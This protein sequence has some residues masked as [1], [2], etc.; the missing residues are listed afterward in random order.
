[1][2]KT[3]F[4]YRCDLR[5]F[6]V[7]CDERILEAARAKRIDPRR[8][9]TRLK[10]MEQ[11]S[12]LE[13]PIHLELE[14]GLLKT[15][16]IGEQ[17]L[18]WENNN[19][20]GKIGDYKE[21][22]AY[23]AIV[24]FWINGTILYMK[25]ETNFRFYYFPSMNGG[26]MQHDVSLEVNPDFVA[27]ARAQQIDEEA[28]ERKA[29]EVLTEVFGEKTASYYIRYNRIYSWNNGLMTNLLVPGDRAGLDIDWSDKLH[30][31]NMDNPA[32]AAAVFL[33]STYWLEDLE[34]R[35]Q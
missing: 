14:G 26:Y 7:E 19:L 17:G 12:A 9:E 21:I 29:K 4:R 24:N 13:Y 11:A 27:Y 23:F 16:Q 10:N 6:S 31:H 25:Q 34:S 2:Q 15:I 28:Y 33:L 3:P 30:P 35:L 18:Y 1:M 22:A 5:S 8:F 32:Q 20:K